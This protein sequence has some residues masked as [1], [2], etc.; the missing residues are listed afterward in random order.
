MCLMLNS[1]LVSLP[2]TFGRMLN[3][4]KDLFQEIPK[5]LPSLQGIEHQVDFVS[6]TSLPNQLTYKENL[7]EYPI[8][9]LDDLLDELHGVCVCVFSKIDLRSGYHQ[10]HMKE[11]DEWKTTF[12]I[13][14]KLYEWLVMPFGLTNAPSTFMRLMN[15]VLR[16]FI[17]KFVVVYFDDILVYFGCM[18]DPVMHVK[19]VLFLLKQECLVCDGSQG[20]KVDPIKIKAIQSWP[21]PKIVGDVRSFHGIASFY[22]HFVKDFSTLVLPLNEIWEDSQERTFQALK[23]KLTCAPILA[24]PNFSKTFELECDTYNV[25]VGAVLLQN[26]HSIAYF[27]KKLKNFQ[28]NF[29]TYDNDAS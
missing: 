11:G 13:K 26:G 1:P 21:T 29:S 22:R 23:E 4:F 14:L 3:E 16:E 2:V 6:R 28:I 5:G 25:G 24:L 7:E 10:I 17:G 18:D 27:S 20:V 8:T 19:S 9:R 12:K 15:H